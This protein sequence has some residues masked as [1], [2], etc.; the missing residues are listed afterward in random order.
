[1]LG[2]LNVNIG[3]EDILKEI[4]NESFRKLVMILEREY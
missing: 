4:G 2:D 3:K 1:L